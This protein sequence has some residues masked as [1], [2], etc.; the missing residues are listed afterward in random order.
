M[1]VQ[2]QYSQLGFLCHGKYEF[3]FLS[4]IMHHT[5]FKMSCFHKN[6]HFHTFITV[7]QELHWQQTVLEQKNHWTDTVTNVDEFCHFL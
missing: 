6:V 3:S 1:H 5:S 4:F 2:P 7:V